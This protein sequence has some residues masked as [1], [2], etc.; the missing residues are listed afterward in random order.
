MF[1]AF[2]HS[3]LRR[4]LEFS[5]C[6]CGRVL[7]TTFHCSRVKCDENTF[8]L[9]YLTRLSHTSSRRRRGRGTAS[10]IE[11]EIRE[12][13]W[14]SNGTEAQL[15][16]MC[17]RRSPPPKETIQ[18]IEVIYPRLRVAQPSMERSSMR[19]KLKV[20]SAVSLLCSDCTPRLGSWRR[21][22]LC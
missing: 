16:R 1:S 20:R 4:E 21:F 14:I 2:I 19:V 13:F 5:A 22:F 6:D 18:L 8:T 3:S 11:A 10:S 15:R 7:R 9:E 17:M 12:N